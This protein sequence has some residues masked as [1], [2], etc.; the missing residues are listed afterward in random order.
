MPDLSALLALLKSPKIALAVFLFS[1]ALLF[2]PFESM[3]LKRPAFTTE[4]ESL[5][6]VI[7]FLSAALLG[8]EILSKAWRFIQ[9]PIRTRKRKLFV[10][11][12]FLSLN[13]E[14]LCVLWAMT[15]GGTKIIKGCYDNQIMISLRQK[16][17]LG[18]M[19]GPQSYVEA[20]HYM[21][22]DIFDI[23]K[24]RGYD[25]MPDEFKNSVRFED[26]VREIVHRATDWRRW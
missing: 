10:E 19:L 21:P 3:G 5:F 14:E 23:V 7:L 20:H 26:E 15:Q 9:K 16:R 24:E 11:N 6:V 17:C 12:V 13:L 18:I 8:V 4:Y 1:A 2:A 25:R 22:D